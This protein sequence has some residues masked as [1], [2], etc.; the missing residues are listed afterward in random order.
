M[1]IVSKRTVKEVSL[2]SPAFSDGTGDSDPNLPVH[3]TR[4]KFGFAHQP[5]HTRKLRPI[6]IE[7]T[8]LLVPNTLIDG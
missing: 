2:D 4:F 7:V 6:F 8:Y 3:I 5:N 1:A